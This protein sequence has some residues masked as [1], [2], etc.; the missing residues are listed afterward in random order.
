MPIP[1]QHGTEV[2][3]RKFGINKVY[4]EQDYRQNGN[5]FGDVDVGGTFIYMIAHFF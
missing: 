1:A 2:D 4:V 5:A 3:K